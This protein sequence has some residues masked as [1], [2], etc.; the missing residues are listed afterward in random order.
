MKNFF[1]KVNDVNYEVVVIHRKMK[2]IHYRFRDNKFIVSCSV[3]TPKFMVVSGLDKHAE[4]LIKMSNKTP[5]LD[6]NY[7]YI[8]GNKYDL[9]YPGRFAVQGY[10]DI[11]Y[12]SKEEL[13][14]KLKPIF[15]DFVTSRVRYYEKLMNLPS[16]KVSVR[17]M[18][19]RF[20]SNSRR[21]KRINFAL[22]LVHYSTPIIDSVVVHELAHILVFN[23]SKKFYEVVYKY[24]P[25]YDRYRKMLIKG[26][27]NDQSN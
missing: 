11:T 15:L 19:S 3:F 14:K 4:K 1:Y 24:C 25:N 23:H 16:Y 9:S 13:F 20:G 7:I 21:T 22:S 17:M 8:F 2:S 5:A 18:S 26:I 6:D 12:N 10:K 27:Y